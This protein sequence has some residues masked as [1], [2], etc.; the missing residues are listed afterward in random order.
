MDGGMA[1]NWGREKSIGLEWQSYLP[2]SLSAHSSVCEKRMIRPVPHRGSKG[3]WEA[4]N[5]SETPLF[6]Q[7]APQL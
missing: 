4:Q 5:K 2:C 7:G 6:R 3:H 1:S